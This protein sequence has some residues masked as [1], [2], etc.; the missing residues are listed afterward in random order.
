M[1]AVDSLDQP[2]ISDCFKQTCADGFVDGLE[3]MLADQLELENELLPIPST[4]RRVE[5]DPCAWY[6][7]KL[8]QDCRTLAACTIRK[9]QRHLDRL[10][11]NRLLL[12]LFGN[13]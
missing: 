5:V 9:K 1:V 2:T 10:K 8:L 12:S 11:Q 3:E 4:F 7:T 13:H 6:L